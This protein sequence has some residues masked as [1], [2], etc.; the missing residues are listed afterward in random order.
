MISPE[1]KQSFNVTVSIGA[2]TASAD[3][4]VELDKW[5]KVADDNLYQAKQQGRN[6][7]IINIIND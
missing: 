2:I 1:D 6:R 5:I 3:Y 7:T 4:E